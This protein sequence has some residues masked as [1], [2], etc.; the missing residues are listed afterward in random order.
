MIEY[1]LKRSNRKTL[2]ISVLPD[3]SVEVV[4]PL[5][6][7]ADAID[8]RVRRRRRWI[9]KQRLY[10][11][12]FEPRLTPRRYVPNETHL[13]LGRQYRLALKN[14]GQGDAVSADGARLIVRTRRPA[15]ARKV[16][17]LIDAWYAT[18]AHARFSARLD[19]L[20]T[21]F[22]R[23]GLAKPKVAV[24]SLKRRWGSLSHA[25]TLTLNRALIQAPPSCI[26]YVIVHELCHLVQADHGPKFYALLVRLM[27]DW[28]KR[29]LRLERMLARDSD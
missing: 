15:S 22:A 6:A 5:R 9:A 28:Q 29:K 16:E 19:A 24:R 13:Y 25:G 17:A 3:G 14:G 11:A 18:R 12:Q 4:A 2:A 10:F 23:R 7:S 21:P 26:D 20:F 27:P 8:N 1:A